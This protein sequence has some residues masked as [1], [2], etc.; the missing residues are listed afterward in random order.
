MADST[1]LDIEAL[2]Q[3]AVRLRDHA[4]A[5]RNPAAQKKLGTDLHTAADVASNMAHFRFVIAELAASLP[6]GNFARNELLALLGKPDLAAAEPAFYA[7][8]FDMPEPKHVAANVRM[9]QIDIPSLEEATEVVAGT[10][11][12]GTDYYRKHNAVIVECRAIATSV[13]GTNLL[14]RKDGEEAAQA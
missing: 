14:A 12:G 7:I 4:D 8:I 5:I 2:N 6:A 9:A 10:L 1:V 11:E 13:S 3:L